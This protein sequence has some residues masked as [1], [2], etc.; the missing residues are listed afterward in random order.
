MALAATLLVAWL[1]AQPRTPDLAAQVYR[2]DLFGRSGFTIWDTH[3]YGGHLVPGYSLLFPAL[4]SLLGVRLVGVAAALVS[5]VLFERIATRAY[6]PSGR[7]AA[8][9]FALGAAADVWIGRLSF[10][11]GVTFAL[12]AAL[13]LQRGRTAWAVALACVCA[14]G[15]PVAGALLGLGALTVSLARRSGRELLALAVP[16][17]V[18]VG[19]LGLLFPEGGWEPFPIRSF[20]ATAVVAIAFLWAL[21][22]GERLLRIG[23][24]LFLLACLA[25]LLVHSPMGSNIE[26]YGVLLAGPL[27]LAS[28]LRGRDA[29]AL[30]R[31]PL[32][33]ARVVAALCLICVWVVWG[34]VRETVAAWGD[35][36]TGA[37]YYAPVE[38]FFARVPGGPFRVEV[39]LT[40]SHWEVALLAPSVPLARGWEKQLDERYDRVLLASGLTPASYGV[41]LRREAVAF[42]ALP[43]ATLDPS[44]AQEG[45]LI[46]A[47]LPYLREVFASRHW[48]IYE[49]LAATP[50]LSGPG[51]LETLASDSFTVLATRAGGMLV[52]LHYNRYLTVT[53]GVGCVGP[54]GGGWTGVDA[55]R[56]GRLTVAA[57]FSL[58]AALSGS[59]SCSRDGRS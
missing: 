7:W 37:S 10:A 48:R 31:R 29:G 51:R 25:C 38:R 16:A 54:G 28:W 17:A 34:P 43:D 4:G 52:R 21:P 6:G 59:K 55:A 44:S 36:A 27:L 40:R 30:D 20:A 15:S 39:P 18:V 47:G 45:R 33:A 57:R 22:A 58:G 42:V 2:A 46:G 12:A 1:I 5:V 13:A 35:A 56:P 9:L 32:S 11:L 23:G 41:W 3:W 19:A 50:L 26:R 49:V 14:A 53:A 8:V 24:A